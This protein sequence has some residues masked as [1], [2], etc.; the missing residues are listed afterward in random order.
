MIDFKN[1]KY[2]ALVEEACQKGKITLLEDIGEALD[3]TLANIVGKQFMT[4][5]KKAKK[6]QTVYVGDREITVHKSF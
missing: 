1:V 4:N 3:P 2:A 5:E 6:S